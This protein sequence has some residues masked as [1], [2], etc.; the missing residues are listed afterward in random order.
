LSGCTCRSRGSGRLLGRCLGRCHSVPLILARRDGS[1]AASD[2]LRCLTPPPP[3][4]SVCGLRRCRHSSR[5]HSDWPCTEGLVAGQ[6]YQTGAALRLALL[7]FEGKRLPQLHAGGCPRVEE[8][9]LHLQHLRRRPV[10]E[11]RGQTHPGVRPELNQY[12]SND[13]SG[14][15]NSSWTTYRRAL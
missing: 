4:L 6:T 13:W 7:A 14:N 15:A 11:R 2:S 3:P 1:D 12:R 5:R 9:L 10:D 8:V